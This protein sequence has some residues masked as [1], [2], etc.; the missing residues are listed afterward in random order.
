M[1]INPSQN[2]RQWDS[3]RR[4]VADGMLSVI[5]P[6]FNL[7]PS[8]AENIKTVHSVFNGRIPFEIIVVDDGSAD[9][10]RQEIEKSAATYANVKSVPL[11]RNVG[12]GGALKHGF[13]SSSG[14][15][16][17]FLD[18]DLDLPADQ[19]WKFFEIM[20][21]EHVDIV[22]GSKHHPDASVSSYPWHRKLVSTVYYW[23]VKILMGF[24]VLDTQTGIKLYRREVLQHTFHRMLVKT[25][26]FDIELLAIAHLKGYRFADCPVTLNAKGKWALVNLRTTFYIFK[27]TLAVFYRMRILHYYQTIRDHNVPFQ[28]PLV[29]IV[30]A[31]PAATTY[32]DE[33]LNGIA[34]QYYTNFEVILLPDEASNRKWPSYARE[35]PTGRIRPAEKRNLGIKHAKGEII[36]L[37]DDDAAPLEKWLQQ[38]IPYFSA[39]DIAAVGGPASTPPNDPYM[40]QLSGKVYATRLVSGPYRYRYEPGIVQD[41]DDYPSCNL[42][43]RTDVM[44]QLGGFRTDFWPGEDTYLCL[45]IT[46]KLNLRI[47]YDPRV[48]AYHHRRK[49]FLP[50]LRQIG[51]YAMHRGYFA[52]RFPET[53]RKLSYML[54]SIFTFGV[55]GGAVVA[56]LVPPLRLFYFAVLLIYAAISFFS[57]FQLNPVSWLLVWLGVMLTH[58]VYGV[59][60]VIGIFAAKLPGEIQRFDHPSEIGQMK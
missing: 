34:R 18:A 8:I 15:H 6:A 31:Y 57:S 23:L 22:I 29:S 9:N 4:I 5:M 46:R 21:K 36:A 45:D 20:E 33:C 51:R 60:F 32:L 52:K 38:A 56:A 1:D 50:H 39:K 13:E 17:L 59:R 2:T 10:T 44:N 19:T 12:K 42:I 37:L 24:P 55:I 53:S 54:P 3:A 47:V 28:N 16:V 11:T 58:L 49:L 40:S 48:E 43:V 41:V 26:A 30:I 27:D 14:T 35:I 25:F 7:G